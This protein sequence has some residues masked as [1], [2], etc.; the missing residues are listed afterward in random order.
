[1][2]VTSLQSQLEEAFTAQAVKL[3]YLF[4]SQATGRARPDSDVDIAVWWGDEVPRSDYFRRRLELMGAMTAI[5]QTDAVDV[6]VLNE[7]PPL[8]AMEVLRTGRLLFSA[9]D[10]WRVEFQVR[11]VRAYRDTASL[12]RLLAEELEYRVQAGKFGQPEPF[13]PL[14]ERPK[15]C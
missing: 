4:G 6:V 14:E 7:A 3:A 2:E 12:R 1:M 8:L 9:D 13:I 15:P 5:F 10:R 11:T